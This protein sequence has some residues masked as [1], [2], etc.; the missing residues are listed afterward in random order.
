MAAAPHPAVPVAINSAAVRPSAT[1]VDTLCRPGECSCAGIVSVQIPDRRAQIQHERGDGDQGE[2]AQGS[3]GRCAASLAVHRTYGDLHGNHQSGPCRESLPTGLAHI[4]QGHPARAARRGFG[5]G[6]DRRAAR[7]DLAGAGVS[8]RAAGRAGCDQGDLRD[9][10]AAAHR[11]D[12]RGRGAGQ[13]R[14]RA[15]HGVVRG[16]HATA[17]ARTVDAAARGAADDAAVRHQLR[18]VVA[19]PVTQRVPRSG[20]DHHV[21]LLPDRVPAGGRVAAQ[22]RSGARGERAV[23]RSVGAPHVL[24]RRPAAAAPGT[25]RRHAARAARHAGR[26]RRVRRAQ[27]QDVQRQRLRPVSAELQRIGRGGAVAAV[28]SCCAC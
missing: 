10:P 12:H 1:F 14:A 21:L 25:A 23:A 27:V 8:G 15:V 22:P 28:D 7:A 6:G 17:A 20:R 16:A 2:R 13:R 3:F 4:G 26:V 11:P 24:S 19:E 18:L 9:Q 5:G